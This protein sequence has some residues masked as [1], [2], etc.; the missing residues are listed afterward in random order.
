MSNAARATRHP[1]LYEKTCWGLF[2]VND[3]VCSPEIIQN[4][5]AFVDQFSITDLHS[6]RIVH[7]ASHESPIPSDFLDHWE[8]YRT[9]TNGVVVIVSPYQKEGCMIPSAAM[10]I[11]FTPYCK[12]YHPDAATFVA[13]F[14]SVS[15]FR[16][17]FRI[18]TLRSHT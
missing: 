3:E 14:P 4:R 8:A 13:V 1:E 2:K 12:M 18:A 15:T 17:I 11:G 5:N 6:S 16:K 9:A 10:R 7:R